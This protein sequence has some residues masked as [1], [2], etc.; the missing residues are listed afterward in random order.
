[1][2]RQLLVLMG[3][4]FGCSAEVACA[5]T[6]FWQPV[7]GTP[8]ASSHARDLAEAEPPIETGP[9]HQALQWQQDPSVPADATLGR[10]LIWEP[11]GETDPNDD[12]VVSPKPPA[13]PP[14]SV[15]E[16]QRLLQS[17]RLPSPLLQQGFQMPSAFQLLEGDFILS[18]NFRS[19]FPPDTI[20]P[21]SSTSVFAGWTIHF[22]LTE[23]TELGFSFHRVDSSF[24]GKQ[25]P[26]FPT[27]GD[28]TS[29]GDNGYTLQ[30]QQQFWRNDDSTQAFGAV[31]S[32]A[33]GERRINFNGDIQKNNDIVPALQLPFSFLPTK[34]WQITLAPT[35]AFFSNKSALFLQT[36]P[37][38]DPGSFGTTAGLGGSTTIKLSDRITLWADAFAPF[39]GANSI[40]RSS[41]KPDR[42][43]IYNAGLRYFVNP[44]LALDLYASNS[45]GT[46]APLALTA[47]PGLNAIGTNLVFMPDLTGSERYADNF[48]NNE[49]VTPALP[50]GFGLYSGGMAPARTVVL[51]VS[52]GGQGFNG[53]LTYGFVNDLDLSLYLGYASGSVDESEQGI[54]GRV[55][56]LDQYHGAAFTAT[57]VGTIGKTNQPFLNYFNNNRQE[58]ANSGQSKTIPL[59]SDVDSLETGQLWVLTASLPLQYQ[60]N[61]GAANSSSIWVAPIL[62]FVQRLDGFPLAGAN[63]G[64]SWA[65]SDELSLIGELGFNA[66]NRG[67]GFSGDSL[68]NLLPWNIGFRWNPARLFGYL[69][70]P[71]KS[72][73]QI[74][75]YLTNRVGQTPWL[76]MRVR[77]QNDLALGLG[78]SFPLRLKY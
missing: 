29:A 76:Q 26:F 77:D 44:R 64:A 30:V 6:S 63:F 31:L 10:M 28:G 36:A 25:G 52:A 19:Y 20:V 21:N 11:V 47:N 14:N 16:A 49:S 42:E 37:I 56:L 60:F 75:A 68:T 35:V 33:F 54:A 59:F 67:N 46:L 41:G 4:A 74:Y 73:P 12:A 57:L 65:I 71:G 58:F 38:A 1:M 27:L 34:I 22:G 13:Q 3:L 32:A 8:A 40:N 70:E 66:G 72:Y 48:T 15:E 17:L 61:P 39:A 2:R 7:T 50:A 55:R 45:E 24:P 53:T 43:I 69:I 51:D 62:G 5:Q 23:S 9:Q 18:A 78:I